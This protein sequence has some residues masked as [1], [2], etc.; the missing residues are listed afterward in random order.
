MTDQQRADFLAGQGFGLDT[1][2]FLESLQP[3][4]VWFKAA[5]QLVPLELI[6]TQAG[7]TD[8]YC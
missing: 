8:Q 5:P 6:S 3:Q 2:P 4:G 7:R 1:M